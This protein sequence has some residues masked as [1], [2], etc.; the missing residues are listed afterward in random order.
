MLNVSYDKLNF[1]PN[2][3]SIKNKTI[4]LSRRIKK[5]FKLKKRRR[6]KINIGNLQHEVYPDQCMGKRG[7]KISSVLIEI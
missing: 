6:K 7:I 5:I 2:K 4:L 1:N 3:F